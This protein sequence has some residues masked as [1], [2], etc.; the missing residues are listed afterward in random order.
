MS[1]LLEVDP[2]G[3]DA[4]SAVLGQGIADP[5]A[6]C[7]ARL[8][9][10]LGGSYAMAGSDPAGTAWAHAY[11]DAVTT[12]LGASQDV[13]NGCFRLAAL[14][15]QTGFNYGYAETSSIPG[16]AARTPPDRSDYE[17]RSAYSACVPTAAGGSVSAPSGWPTIEHAVG[18]VWPNGHQDRLR[19]AGHAWATSA[20]AV[21]DAGWYVIDAVEAI[22]AQNTP[23]VDDALTAC[24]AMRRHLED[25]AQIHAALADACATY[26]QHVD[27]ARGEIRHE[28]VSLAE[29]TAGI[30]AGGFA[31]GFFTF[32]AADVAAQAAEAGRIAAI[33]ARVAAVIRRLIEMAGA[34]AETISQATARVLHISRDLRALLG[35]RLSIASTEA[36]GELP[37][38]A[39]VGELPVAARTAETI[40]EE[41]LAVSA[42][43]DASR[44]PPAARARV[45]D[46]VERARSGKIRFPGHDGKAYLNSDG[47]LPPRED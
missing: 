24:N 45:I 30:E 4:A 9:D 11:D 37:V 15:Q 14:L 31:L 8:C 35:A 38:A 6:T 40:A 27:D 20:D 34:A 46:A 43:V 19:V 7:L 33:A 5:L 13:V 28:L 25:L 47:L 23:E 2:A 21:G 3:Y 18:Y 16:P 32:G 42:F 41:R 12:T 44:I 26:A 39:R 36:V 17:H 22:G 29:W 10:A 1:A